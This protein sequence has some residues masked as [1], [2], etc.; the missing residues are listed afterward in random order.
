[1]GLARFPERI[2]GGVH[3]LA[4]ARRGTVAGVID[5]QRHNVVDWTTADEAVMRGVQRDSVATG[6]QQPLV[7]IGRV[8]EIGF[9]PAGNLRCLIDADRE[10]HVDHRLFDRKG[11]ARLRH[12][13]APKCGADRDIRPAPPALREV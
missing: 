11:R 2:D 9:R 8:A 1:M 4:L 5:H 7:G 10:D 3:E 13:A 12:R 6:Q